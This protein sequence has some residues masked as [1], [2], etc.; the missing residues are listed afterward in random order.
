M[1][2]SASTGFAE[3]MDVMHS[4]ADKFP[5]ISSKGRY[6]DLEDIW[7]WEYILTVLLEKVCAFRKQAAKGSPLWAVGNQAACRCM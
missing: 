4:T 6:Y 3:N 1:H 2:K 7:Q 5:V